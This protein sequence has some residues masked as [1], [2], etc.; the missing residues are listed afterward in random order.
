[1]SDS[2]FDNDFSN[3]SSDMQID[4]QLN[5]LLDIEKAKV[6]TTAQ[7]NYRCFNFFNFIFIIFD[8]HVLNYAKVTFP[9]CLRY[10]T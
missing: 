7:V 1:M 2:T 5:E 4:P 10:F 9:N 3:A 6:A 8:N